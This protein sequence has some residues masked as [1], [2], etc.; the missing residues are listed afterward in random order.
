MTKTYDIVGKRKIYYIVSSAIILLALIVSFV[1]GVKVD[2]QFKGGTMISYSYTGEID[3][4]Q[5]EKTVSDISGQSVSAKK[6]QTSKTTRLLL[7]F[8]L[9][10]KKVFHLMFSHRLLKR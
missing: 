5:I 2:I 8:L 1:F 7:K 10:R 3:K 6:V 9:H 4:A